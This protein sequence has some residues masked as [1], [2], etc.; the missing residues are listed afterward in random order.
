V[1]DA[2]Y[3]NQLLDEQI[4]QSIDKQLSSKGL[5]KTENNPDL[6]VIYQVAVTQEKQGFGV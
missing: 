3:P 5:T 6:Y 1:P 2:Q 4:M